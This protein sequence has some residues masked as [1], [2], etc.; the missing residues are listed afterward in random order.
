MSSKLPEIKFSD[1]VRMM[2]RNSDKKP[3][4]VPYP[5]PIREPRWKYMSVEEFNEPFISNP[6]A[7][8]NNKKNTKK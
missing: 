2:E 6:I 3:N 4:S 5:P 1:I 8:I 7:E